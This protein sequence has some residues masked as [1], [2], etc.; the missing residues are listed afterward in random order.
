MPTPPVRL[1]AA[2]LLGGLL[3][4]ACGEQSRID[5]DAAVTFSGTVRGP[6]GGPLADRPVRLASGVGDGDVALAVVT[7]GLACTSGACRDRVASARTTE[8]GS[9]RLELQGRDTQTAFGGVRPQVLSAAAAPRGQEVSGASVSAR[10]VVQT[11]DVR[12]PPL[13]LVDPRL[14]VRGDRARVGSSWTASPGAPYTLSFEGD[15]VVPAWQTVTGRT[16]AT[17]DSRVLEDTRGRVVL[18]GALREEITGSDL[19][20]VWRSPGTGYVSGA[21]APPSRGR[22]CTYPGTASPCALTDGD[23]TATDA[24]P[25]GC[26]SLSPSSSAAPCVPPT[27][28][29]VD[30]GGPVPAEL[31]VVRGC[32][33]GCAVDVSGDGRTFRPAGSVADAFGAVRLPGADVRAVRVGL[34]RDG[35]REVSVWGALP[36]EAGLQ[37]LPARVVERLRVPYAVGP[38]SDDGL[39][40]GVVAVA[41]GLVVAGLVGLGV[42][43]GRRSVRRG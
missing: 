38:G 2:V 6:A 33:G 18:S 30:L 26:P 27:T 24:P 14:S 5:P 41:A 17:L 42:L 39:P 9:Y 40:G 8:T 23:L 32:S 35:L 3:T 34:G 1:V 11:N 4:A 43:L 28:V 22:A 15:D 16:S 37:A 19:D 12:L 20:V 21:G 25:I 10:F 7:L 31:V 13:R 36:A 29:V